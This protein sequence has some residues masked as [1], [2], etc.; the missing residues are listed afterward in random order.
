L[1]ALDFMAAA[2]LDLVAL[3]AAVF[4]AIARLRVVTRFF[5]AVFFAVAR[6]RVV[7]RFFA[8]FRARAVAADEV[9]GVDVTPAAAATLGGSARDAPIGTAMVNSGRW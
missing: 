5:A 6:L 3:F 7:A 1:G 9:R 4:F 8:V 2:R